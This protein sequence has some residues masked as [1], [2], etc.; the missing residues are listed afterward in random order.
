MAV[1]A[2]KTS[3]ARKKMRRAGKKLKAP[4]ISFDQ[5][6]GQWE[7]SHH[8]KSDGTYGQHKVR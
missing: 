5:R 8:V 1:P 3:K 4:A 6:T 2:R 7:L